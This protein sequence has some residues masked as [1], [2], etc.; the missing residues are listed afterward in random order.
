[1]RAESALNSPAI[2]GSIATIDYNLPI[3][4]EDFVPIALTAFGGWQ[5][6]R[7]M[8]TRDGRLGLVGRV[9]TVFLVAGGLCKAIWKLMQALDGPDYKWLSGALFPLLCTGFALLAGAMFA[10]DYRENGAS[11]LQRHPAVIPAAIAAVALVLAFVLSAATGWSRAYVIP[12][13]GLTT[14]ASLT[15]VILGFKAGRRRAKPLIGAAFIANFLGVLVLTR[16]AR[17]E[18]QTIALQWFEQSINTVATAMW[19]WAGT[20]LV[21]FDRL[22]GAA[23]R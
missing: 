7:W 22:R 17:L 18:E 8:T 11:P 1:L 15:V 5:L 6:S 4:I 14:L 9:G 2:T 3:A 21:R 19:A 23:N 13:L 16:L 20:Q 12:T 10:H